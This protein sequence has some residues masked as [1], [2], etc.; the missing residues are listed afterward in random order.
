[1]QGAWIGRVLTYFD[2]WNIPEDAFG[3]VYSDIND[4]NGVLGYTFN[5]S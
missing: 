5:E 3:D 1:M 4:F 2:I